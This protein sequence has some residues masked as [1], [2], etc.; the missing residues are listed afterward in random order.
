MA[1]PAINLAE[2]SCLF[3]L[4]SIELLFEPATGCTKRIGWNNWVAGGRA[5][6]SLQRIRQFY[7]LPLWESRPLRAGEG[8]RDG[9]FVLDTRSES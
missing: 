2:M 5:L 1:N 9:I 7:P 6:A 8:L 4:A 3:E